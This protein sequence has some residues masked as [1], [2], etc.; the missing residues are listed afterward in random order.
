MRGRCAWL[1]LLLLAAAVG[2]SEAAQAKRL[3]K[4]G[5]LEA[6]VADEGWCGERVYLEIRSPDSLPFTGDKLP[7]RRMVGML[8]DIMAG[9][10]PAAESLTIV[11]LVNGE[12]SFGGVASLREGTV[13]DAAPPQADGRLPLDKRAQIRE[14]Q[15]SLTAL[16]FAPGPIDGVMGQRTF[17]AITE[18][19][20]SR[21]LP[22]NGDL[23]PTL[24]A[25][26]RAEQGKASAHTA[27]LLKPG[28]EPKGAIVSQNNE[29]ASGSSRSA[30]LA[31]GRFLPI[32][33][34]FDYLLGDVLRQ[35]AAIMNSD[36]FVIALLAYFGECDALLDVVGNEVALPQF[37]AENRQR[38]LKKASALPGMA[39]IVSSVSREV[40]LG[41][42]D[43][44]KRVFP[45]D[46]YSASRLG[47]LRVERPRKYLC[48]PR[49][50]QDKAT[51]RLERDRSLWITKTVQES[52]FPEHFTVRL[53]T[54]TEAMAVPM[55]T[56]A[57]REFI[58]AGEAD[59]RFQ[60]E[61]DLADFRLVDTNL[62]YKS[63]TG[64]FRPHVSKAS[65]VDPKN[66]LTLFERSF[67]KKSAPANQVDPVS[68]PRYA[69]LMSYAER[70]KV[71]RFQG[72]LI[73]SPQLGDYLAALT[74]KSD[75]RLIDRYGAFKIIN[76]LTSEAKRRELITQG[77]GRPLS[78]E[79]YKAFER[80]NWKIAADD[81][82]K[83]RFRRT[84][85]V[86]E[87][88]WRRIENSYRAYMDARF[89]EVPKFQS[90][91][92]IA[93][94]CMATLGSYDFQERAF[95]LLRPTCDRSTS[96]S[97]KKLPVQFPSPTGFPKFYSVPE[98]RAQSFK[99]GLGRDNAIYFIFEG[100]LES[101]P[102]Y[103]QAKKRWPE[104]LKASYSG[105]VS[106]YAKREEYSF[107]ELIDR[108]N[109][110][111]YLSG[112]AP[113][114]PE[115][116]VINA[117]WIGLYMLKSGLPSYRSNKKWGLVVAG[118]EKAGK[119]S[120]PWSPFFSSLGIESLD[121]GN[122]GAL[123]SEF[124]RAF[125]EWNE[126]RLA[127]VGNEASLQTFQAPLSNWVFQS[128]WIPVF[129]RYKKGVLSDSDRRGL[130]KALQ[131]SMDQVFSPPLK[132]SDRH[133][134]II[135]PVAMQ[136]YV[137][138]NTEEIRAAD[139]HGG[140]LAM[141]VD[142]EVSSIAYS[143][144]TSGIPIVTL[145]P[146][147]ARLVDQFGETLQEQDLSAEGGMSADAIRHPPL[148]YF[149]DAY[150]SL[151]GLRP[152]DV[153]LK[154]APDR[155]PNSWAT[156]RLS[157]A[158]TYRES[159]AGEDGVWVGGK[160]KL[161]TYDPA[162]HSFAT[163]ISLGPVLTLPEGSNKWSNRLRLSF[164]QSG[165]PPRVWLEEDQ[166]ADSWTSSLASYP[167]F[168]LRA[169][170]LP[171]YADDKR[172][173]FEII[174]IE[175]LDEGTGGTTFK[176]PP[177]LRY[178]GRP[179]EEAER[180]R[181][182]G[183]FD[184]FGVRL[185]DDMEAAVQ[186]AETAMG[187]ARRY[188]LS[189]PNVA[190]VAD[191]SELQAFTQG[192]ALVSASGNDA[193]TFTGEGPLFSDEV[194]VIGRHLHFP[195]NQR[196]TEQQVF[197]LLTQKYGAPGFE[198]TWR[199]P[200]NIRECKS[201]IWV[202]QR[203]DDVSSASGDDPIFVQTQRQSEHCDSNLGLQ[204][205]ESGELW[206]GPAGSYQ[207][208]QRR[209]ASTWMLPAGAYPFTGNALNVRRENFDN[210]VLVVR[211]FREHGEERID[212]LFLYI[213]NFKEVIDRAKANYDAVLDEKA[214]QRQEI[215]STAEESE[216]ALPSIKF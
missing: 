203:P 56:E 89:G 186:K 84:G 127:F 158:K 107:S 160:G 144:G 204:P 118:L 210:E 165:L 95:P 166:T 42:Y 151:A 2:L 115:R 43:L 48:P 201:L 91:L 214:G 170:V 216:E 190:P 76:A 36:T 100:S 93:A 125:E 55:S 79:L 3:L 9:I 81:Y 150:A 34:T 16:G 4:D 38:I 168:D 26:L 51:K 135:L 67:E 212:D 178:Q 141:Q 37:V 174:E 83:S 180:E 113:E 116:L 172:L 24:L 96:G 46:K 59:Q 65:L 207:W 22:A 154:F 71:P 41:S 139:P 32:D 64:V 12:A 117:D 121:Q 205:E 189:R 33:E 78:A 191:W 148:G 161:G 21:G 122:D 52:G 69:A 124:E 72:R 130:A 193:I 58:N 47:N 14:A 77:Y 126:Q 35:N 142:V 68:D 86:D 8:R 137:M 10:C 128:E 183:A 149:I 200:A 176:A 18:Y 97:F 120:H 187:D 63:I 44:D 92:P 19:Q 188:T 196:P 153:A 169:K 202:T 171:V 184:V 195:K 57:A 143:N 147:V 99:Q 105:S 111:R 146:V 94:V 62:S 61:I 102:V 70:W 156:D 45:I 211:L 182:V 152:M 133:I 145:T 85:E 39:G 175:I 173:A 98:D 134:A 30:T 17:R 73:G 209:S 109:V 114:R 27:S 167:N 164:A 31:N 108:W 123:S 28:T 206:T 82:R 66:G 60:L 159:G 140:N 181:L 80:E 103:D 75:S 29:A 15:S 6:H 1:S 74:L 106:V 88:D 179:M 23:S 5:T 136:Q 90:G 163:D 13:K 20:L 213:A 11:G 104:K 138:A 198:S 197:Q 177:T 25:R 199:N 157:E 54:D 101:L 7:V 50:T 194:T 131:V 132:V 215:I 185:G 87:F 129:P 119:P 40:T 53:P 192:V 155:V 49:K 208:P 162:T 112:L 110:R